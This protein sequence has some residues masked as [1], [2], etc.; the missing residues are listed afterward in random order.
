M[1]EKFGSVKSCGMGAGAGAIKNGTDG[2]K[3]GGGGGGGGGGS[4][5]ANGKKVNIYLG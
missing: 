4:T 3:E 5:M 2:K 1:G